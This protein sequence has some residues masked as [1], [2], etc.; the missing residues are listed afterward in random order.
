VTLALKVPTRSADWGIFKAMRRCVLL[1]GGL[2]PLAGCGGSSTAPHPRVLVADAREPAALA[3]LP[4]GGL[5]YGELK[6]GVVREVGPGGADRGRVIARVRVSNAGQRG[7]LSLAVDGRDR[8]F[9]AWT[10]PAGRLVVGRVAPGPTRLVWRG[11][12]TVTLGN[13]GHIAFAPDGALVVS[14]GDRGHRHAG[15]LLRLGPG[16]PVTL[17]RGWNNPFAFA[18]DRRGRL[19]VADNS[20]SPREPERLARGDR[21]APADVTAL[22]PRTAPSG[23][24]AV[25]ERLFVCG[26]VSFRLD[27]YRVDAAGRA[28]RDGAPL[29]RDC[30]LGA[31]ALADGR[32]AYAKRDRIEVVRP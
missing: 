16:G 1:A 8:T 3:P 17:S 11:P 5:R 31:V 27:P 30:S 29:A 32:V 7:L 18:F 21:G 23:L 26:V 20:P 14:V 28:R 4:G 9:A 2:L 10:T 13:G 25:G 15:A 6:T 22:P 19:W 12:Q 24:A